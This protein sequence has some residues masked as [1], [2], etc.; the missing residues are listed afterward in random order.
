MR[1][2]LFLCLIAAAGLFIAGCSEDSPTNNGN[3]NVPADFSFLVTINST[4]WKADSAVYRTPVLPTHS[5]EIVAWIGEEN[6]GEKITISLN[7]TTPGTYSVQKASDSI[8]IQFI[9]DLDP[10]VSFNPDPTVATEGTVTI[11]ESNDQYISGTFSFKG[12]GPFSSPNVT[13]TGASGGFKVRA[14]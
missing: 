11:V 6:R 9:A 14:E 8:A 3:N 13:Y 12:T 10:G 5:K 7:R 2:T 1:N 4:A